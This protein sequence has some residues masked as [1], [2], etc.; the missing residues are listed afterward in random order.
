[1]REAGLG[2]LARHVGGLTI[3]V[4]EARRKPCTVAILSPTRRRRHISIAMFEI[5]NARP[6]LS[7][8]GLGADRTTSAQ[9][10]LFPVLDPERGIRHNAMLPGI[11]LNGDWAWPTT[12]RGGWKSWISPNTRRSSPST[13]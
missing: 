7:P 5:A 2:N 9:A 4:A 12:S 3:P 11:M 1:M 13:R 8:T 6:S 10:G